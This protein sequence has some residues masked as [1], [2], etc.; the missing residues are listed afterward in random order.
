M[1]HR[2]ERAI[3]TIAV[4]GRH[5]GFG[6]NAARFAAALNRAL[7]SAGDFYVVDGEFLGDIVH[8]VLKVQGRFYDAGGQTTKKA[9]VAR[10]GKAPAW[11]PCDEGILFGQA[12]HPKDVERPIDVAALEAELRFALD[13]LPGGDGGEGP[14]L[15][16]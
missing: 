13:P 9:I 8:V 6:G 10:W 7:D 4:T 14:R 11:L 15:H 12:D 3:S 16:S 2:I 1:K 5:D